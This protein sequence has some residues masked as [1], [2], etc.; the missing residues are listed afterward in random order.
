[1]RSTIA[2]AVIAVAVAY[3]PT[4]EA[5]DHSHEGFQFRGAL[6]G[7]YLSDNET[8]DGSTTTATISG[9]AAS[10]EAFFGGSPEP[11]YTVGGF[12]SGSS[13]PGPS[14]SVN[15]RPVGSTNSN[16]S[17][18]F[19]NIG[20]YFDWY[21]D[22]AE[23][24]HALATLSFARLTLTTNDQQQGD[25]ATGFGLGLGAGYDWWVGKEWSVGVLG[26]FTYG[27]L[28]FGSGSSATSESTIAPM[29]LASITYQ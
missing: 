3:A 9:G 29:V 23:G 25:A 26:R 15:G 16:T 14:L 21:P 10:L 28:K 22:P 11:G 19:A 7:G 4:S 13:A 27:S 2:F 17:L 8:P 20:P 18:N 12:V 5:G 6:G 24:F 1:M